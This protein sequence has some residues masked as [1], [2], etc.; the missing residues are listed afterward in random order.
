MYVSHAAKNVFAKTPFAC[1][2]EKRTA[3]MKTMTL[4]T[5]WSDNMNHS[6]RLPSL[7]YAGEGEF[8]GAVSIHSL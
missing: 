3:A 4:G 6:V 5:I 8:N 7:R 2:I 1:A